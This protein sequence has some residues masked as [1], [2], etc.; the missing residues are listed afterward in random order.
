MAYGRA[1][2]PAE[3]E[4]IRRARAQKPPVPSDEL[5]RQLG[6]SLGS[7]TSCLDR[8]GLRGKPNPVPAD[9]ARQAGAMRQEG[10]EWSQIE[11][12]FDH[13][14]SRHR[15]LDAARAAGMVPKRPRREVLSVAPEEERPDRRGRCRC[16]GGCGLFFQSEDV[17]ANRICG[18][19][20][21]GSSAL[22]A[23]W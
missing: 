16:L 4:V 2:T 23:G 15:L 1:F 11:A 7:V 9:I 14:Y 22:P 17:R 18:S 19:C 8:L 21:P 12:R 20:R 5:A 3:I 13:A 10:I 6:R